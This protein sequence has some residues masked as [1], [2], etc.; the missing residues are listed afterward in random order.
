[1]KFEEF[2]LA[3]QNA[4]ED[5]LELWFDDPNTTDEDMAEFLKI[6]NWLGEH[7]L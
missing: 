7:T 6:E 3:N 1:M 4:K 5:A 2:K